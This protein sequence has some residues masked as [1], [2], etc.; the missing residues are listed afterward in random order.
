MILPQIL[1]SSL[2]ATSVLATGRAIVTNQCDE[3]I[4][5]WSVGG[6]ISNQTVLLKD[7]SY[8]EIFTS[9]PESGGISLKVT[10]TPDGI[11]NPNTS[12]LIFAYSIDES[13]V[14][15]N[16]SSVQGNGFAGRTIRLQPSDET[17][18][19]ISWYDGRA[20]PGSQIKHCQRESNLELTFCTGHCLPS[21][22]KHLFL[23]SK[24]YY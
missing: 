9:D 4:Y 6:T 22:C 16:L 19:P 3:P 13:L 8:S 11:F 20:P 24:V 23:N 18:D 1:V 12:Q 2:L 14:W 17:C 15:Y 5:L 7:S 21:W 10:S